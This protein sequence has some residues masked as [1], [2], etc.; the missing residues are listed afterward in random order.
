MCTGQTALLSYSP[1]GGF[2]SGS[3]LSGNNFIPTASGTHTVGYNYTDA[4]GCTYSDCLPIKVD[5]CTDIREDE[6]PSV[7]AHPNPFKNE[8]VVNNPGGIKLNITVYDVN[9]R[10]ILEQRTSDNSVVNLEGQSQGIYYV[11]MESETA[12]KFSKLI[13]L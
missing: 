7:S 13:K 4:Y 12:C 8:F 9:G 3:F 2:L 10:I 6:L 11:K 5:L 1:S